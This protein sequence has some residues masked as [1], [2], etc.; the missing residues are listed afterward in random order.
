MARWDGKYT[1]AVDFD[2]VIHLYKSGWKDLDIIEDDPHEDAWRVLGEYVE[3]FHVHIFSARGQEQRGIE[4]MKE[5][6][7]KHNCPK[8][9]FDKLHFATQKPTAHLY[10]DDRAFCFE[11]TFPTVEAIKSFKPWNKR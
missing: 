7:K 8:E 5:W 2:G 11:G 6:F 9:I 10:I 4:A 1:I 3:H